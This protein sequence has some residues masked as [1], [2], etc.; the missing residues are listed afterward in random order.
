MN[1][2]AS[3]YVCG[4]TSEY[5]LESTILEGGE[6]LCSK[7]SDR[8]GHPSPTICSRTDRPMN[9]FFAAESFHTKKLYSRLCSRKVQFSIRKTK[10]L[11]PLRPPIGEGVS[12]NVRTLFIL[13]SLEARI[14][15]FLL[16]ITELFFASCYACGATNEYR[17]ESAVLE[18]G[19]SF[20]VQNFR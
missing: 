3:C 18:G 20:L 16:I 6:S 8:R 14:V 19:G 9:A 2:F 5:R 13:G 17:L 1:F 15:D 11:S 12:G 7:I 10:K 4:A